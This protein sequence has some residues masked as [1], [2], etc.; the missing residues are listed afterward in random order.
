MKKMRLKTDMVTPVMH[1]DE[2]GQPLSGSL[3]AEKF[4]SI[5]VEYPEPKVE[6]FIY[7]CCGEVVATVKITY[8]DDKKSHLSLVERL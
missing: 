7:K 3:V 8:L 1:V 5:A 4:D 6:K 2:Y